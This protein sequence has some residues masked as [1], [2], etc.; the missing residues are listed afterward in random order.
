VKV[1]R[2]GQ[3]ILE[4]AAARALD[5]EIVMPAHDAEL[6]VRFVGAE[7]TAHCTPLRNRHTLPGPAQPTLGVH[8]LLRRRG[9]DLQ[10]QVWLEV[11]I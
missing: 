4:V 7:P 3:R 11:R 1:A 8:G 2:L 5:L 6:V 9:T 10:M